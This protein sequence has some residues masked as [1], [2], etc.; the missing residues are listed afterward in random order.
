MVVGFRHDDSVLKPY[1][2]GLMG[3]SKK[4]LPNKAN[5]I[6]QQPHQGSPTEILLTWIREVTMSTL[7]I[8]SAVQST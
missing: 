4:C 8:N 6:S 3:S 5:L 2:R 1:D 7:V